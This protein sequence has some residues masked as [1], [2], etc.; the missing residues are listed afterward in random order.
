MMTVM[1]YLKADIIHPQYHNLLCL[2]QIVVTQKARTIY[3]KQ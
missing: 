2:G 1:V 3:L